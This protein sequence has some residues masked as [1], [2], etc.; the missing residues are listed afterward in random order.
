MPL[1]YNLALLFLSPLVAVYLA[2]RLWIQG[3][4]REGFRQR[5]GLAPRRGEPAAQGRVWLHAVSAGEVVA[6]AAIVRKLGASERSP[7]VVISCT[8]PAGY[9]QARKLVPGAAAHF[10]FPF[11]FLPCVWLA[12]RRVRPTAVAAV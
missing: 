9:Q 1:I 8:T 4:G 12:L 10:Y 6:A 11:D 2:H 5:L 7:E 3:K